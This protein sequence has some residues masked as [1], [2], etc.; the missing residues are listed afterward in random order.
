MNYII[1]P[2]F[3]IILQKEIKQELNR[4]LV[5]TALEVKPKSNLYSYRVIKIVSML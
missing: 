1:R 2:Y 4:K 3:L 5:L